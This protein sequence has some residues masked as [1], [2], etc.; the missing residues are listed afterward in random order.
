M[1]NLIERVKE[2]MRMVVEQNVGVIVL[3]MLPRVEYAHPAEDYAADAV[4]MHN[5]CGYKRM[6]YSKRSDGLK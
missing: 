2:G 5:P 4:R 6:Q 1:K 3:P